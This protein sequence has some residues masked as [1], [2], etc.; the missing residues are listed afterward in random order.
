MSTGFT[1]NPGSGGSKFGADNE[2]SGTELWPLVKAAWGAAGS[3]QNVTTAQPLPVQL[4]ADY[5]TVSSVNSSTTQLAASATFTGTIESVLAFP[6]LSILLTSD[7]AITLTINQFIDAAGTYNAEPITINVAAGAGLAQS[8]VLNAN[9]FQVTAKNTGASTTTTFNLNV[10]YGQIDP[11]GQASNENS[12]PVTLATNQTTTK[13]TQASQAVGTQD[14]KDS[15]RTYVTLYL[16]AITGITTEAL[17]TMNIN[18]AGT[19]TTGTSWSVPTGKTF[20]IQAIEGTVKASSTTA[21]Y[22]RIRL[23]S[24]ATVAATSGIVANLDVPTMVAGTIAAGMGGAISYSVPDG[25][26]I[27]A[28]QQVGISHIESSTSS[29]VSCIVTGY[30]Y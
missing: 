10:A 17:A 9:Y 29:T 13:G 19:V 16:D 21:V 27:A 14:L 8:I 11:Q 22:G 25:L 26:E 30:Y 3:G 23:R 6:V 15:G 5:F 1:A 18:T 24:A 12:V 2:N 7:Q 28:S 20:R 4:A